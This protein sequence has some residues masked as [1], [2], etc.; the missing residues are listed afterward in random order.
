MR[1]LPERFTRAARIDIRLP[2]SKI[3]HGLNFVMIERLRAWSS[4]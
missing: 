2:T 1:F 4:R 3:N